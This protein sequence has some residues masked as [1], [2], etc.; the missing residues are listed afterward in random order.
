[1]DF[2]HLAAVI[3][4]ESF[5][6]LRCKLREKSAQFFAEAQMR[7]NDCQGF[8]IEVGHVH[9]IANRSLEQSR[10]NRVRDL[11]PNTL[12]CL[13][14]GRAEMRSEDRKSTRLNSSH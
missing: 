5:S 3:D 11:N 4:V 1:I 7:A 2:V 8:R 14:G 6:A 12:L 13:R 9:G 10:T